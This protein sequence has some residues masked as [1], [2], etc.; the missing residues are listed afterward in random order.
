VVGG[1]TKRRVAW[2]RV[3]LRLSAHPVLW[4][5]ALRQAVLCARPGW[6]RRPPFLP[7][8]EPG[9]LRFRL[10]TAHGEEGTADADDLVAYLRW[11]RG[12]RR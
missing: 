3:V 4:P 10:E 1:S 7:L 11:C 5:T 12:R 8:P 6:W 9:Y 2:L